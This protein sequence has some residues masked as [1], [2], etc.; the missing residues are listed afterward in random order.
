MQGCFLRISHY[1]GHR[2]AVDSPNARFD[3]TALSES[4]ESVR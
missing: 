1:N 2:F 4:E 3:L